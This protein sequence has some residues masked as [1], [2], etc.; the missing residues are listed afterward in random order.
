VLAPHRRTVRRGWLRLVV[1]RRAAVLSASASALSELVSTPTV[2]T[3]DLSAS[4]EVVDHRVRLRSAAEALRRLPRD[5]L[6]ACI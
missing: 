5:G 4:E 2:V 6:T 3:N 1:A